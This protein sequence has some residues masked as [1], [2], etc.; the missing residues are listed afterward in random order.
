MSTT[1]SQS[2]SRSGGDQ[3]GLVKWIFPGVIAVLILVFILQNTKDQWRVHLFFWWFSLP[4]WLMVVVLLVIGLLVGMLVSTL[5][6]RRKRR[7][8][9]RRA[10]TK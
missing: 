7:E 5:L 6:R 1:Q 3:R 10:A 2:R 4:A 9:Q 8:M